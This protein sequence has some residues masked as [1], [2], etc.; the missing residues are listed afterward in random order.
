M[1]PIALAP[2][3]LNPLILIDRL[4]PFALIGLVVIVFAE[5]G[6][7][8]GFFLPGDSLLFT[9][10]LLVAA[11]GIGPLWLVCLLLFL[12]AVAGN[13]VGYAI[14]RTAGPALFERPNSRL[15]RREHVE[16][17]QAFFARYGGRAIILARFVPIVR[18][19][20]T[21]MAGVGRMDFRAYAFF[22]AVGALL[23]A[24]GLTVLGYAL[25]DIDWV[26]DSIEYVILGIVV[27]SIVPLVVELV[28]SR[29]AAREGGDGT[30]AG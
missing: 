3:W 12:A 13:L 25:G 16:K 11:G 6:L 14:G 15:F 23:W 7:L 30:A 2:D 17:T 26:K 9:A 21:A 22:S 10:G 24:V 28:R 8:F 1:P 20:I 4:G 5:C 19:F 18:T 27:L 29:A